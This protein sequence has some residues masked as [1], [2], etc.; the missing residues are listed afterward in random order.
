MKT[1]MLDDDEERAFAPAA[2]ALRYGER[3][4]GAA[5]SADH[6]RATHPGEAP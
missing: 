4:N 2:L 3:S 5:A 1:L 6:V